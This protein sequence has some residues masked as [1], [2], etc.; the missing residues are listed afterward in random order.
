[1]PNWTWTKDY[2]REHFAV[3]DLGVYL[4]G[5][6]RVSARVHYAA[7]VPAE[8]YYLVEV[9]AARPHRNLET[10]EVVTLPRS[11]GN[12][13][14]IITR[15]ERLGGILLGLLRQW[16]TVDPPGRAPISV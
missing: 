10:N 9:W 1:M 6:Y 11:D 16:D 13:A 15:T 4:D 2:E 3:C 8:G 12:D 5:D 7:V 14:S